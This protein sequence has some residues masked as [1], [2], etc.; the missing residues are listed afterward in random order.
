MMESYSLNLLGK[1]MPMFRRFFE[2]IP[3]LLL[4]PAAILFGLAPFLPE[5]H[6][7]EK[8]RLLGYGQLRG[9]LDIFDLIL[10]SGPLLLV[11]VKLLLR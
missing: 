1:Q 8:L 3:W 2:K 9:P 6:L 10:H 11:V 4:I 5:P 7:F